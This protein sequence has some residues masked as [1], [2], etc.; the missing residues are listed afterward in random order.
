M[1]ILPLAV[2]PTILTFSNFKLSG[3]QLPEF[4]SQDVLIPQPEKSIPEFWEL[5]SK[6][7]KVDKINLYYTVPLMFFILPFLQGLIYSL[8]NKHYLTVVLTIILLMYY[9]HSLL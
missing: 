3:L 8:S 6:F 4:L 1:V 9:S 7:L 5:K 2:R